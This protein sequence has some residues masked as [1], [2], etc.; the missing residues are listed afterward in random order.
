MTN[1]DWLTGLGNRI[2]TLHFEFENEPGPPRRLE[3][4]L[5][6]CDQPLWHI[7][8]VGRA[9][10]AQ[11]PIC[12]CALVLAETSSRPRSLFSLIVAPAVHR[13]RLASTSKTGL[14]RP[15]VV[16]RPLAPKLPALSNSG[17]KPA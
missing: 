1:G 9:R 16:A 7:D 2:P 12:Y 17:D 10:H 14:L 6:Y 11:K 5:Q 3:H 8:A 13:L 15:A 4:F